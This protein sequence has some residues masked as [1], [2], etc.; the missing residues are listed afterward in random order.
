MEIF[1]N[2]FKISFM[3]SSASS[4]SELFLNIKGFS[5]VNK[6]VIN[7]VCGTFLLA[8]TSIALSKMLHPSKVYLGLRQTSMM[9]WLKTFPLT[10]LIWEPT[11]GTGLFFVFVQTFLSKMLFRYTE[12][13]T[14][15]QAYNP[16]M[17]F[18]A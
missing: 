13:V 16:G 4:S 1:Q 3:Y 15:N 17:I 2:Y 7:Y 10:W 12:S 11:N 18:L 14:Y 6:I 8:Y 5:D 9:K